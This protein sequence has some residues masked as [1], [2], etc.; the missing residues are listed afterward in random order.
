MAYWWARVVPRSLPHAA[1]VR[2]HGTN[3]PLG[4]AIPYLRHQYNTKNSGS[5]HFL[6]FVNA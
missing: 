4:T 6:D 2:M 5:Y 3:N 1:P